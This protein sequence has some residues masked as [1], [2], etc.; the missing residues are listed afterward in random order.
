MVIHA[1]MSSSGN[2]RGS[3]RGAIP[4]GRQLQAAADWGEKEP[5]VGESSELAEATQI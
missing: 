4:L 5:T 3:A 2:P 1:A